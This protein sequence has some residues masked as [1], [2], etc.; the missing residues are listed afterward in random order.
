M[1]VDNTLFSFLSSFFFF[2]FVSFP[3]NTA[4]NQSIWN[5]DRELEDAYAK[6]FGIDPT[7]YPLVV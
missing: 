4:C 6:Q 1:Q 5:K 7:S 2:P 3:F